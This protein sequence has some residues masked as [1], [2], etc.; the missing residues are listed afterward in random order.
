MHPTTQFFTGW[1]PFLPL[2]QQRE[3]TEGSGRRQETNY[4]KY[5]LLIELLTFKSTVKTS[6]IAEC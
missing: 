1:M 4:F 3:S 5:Q 2:N 6:N